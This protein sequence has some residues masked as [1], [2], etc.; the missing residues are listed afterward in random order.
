MLQEK[1]TIDFKTGNQLDYDCCKPNPF[2][3]DRTLGLKVI[4]IHLAVMENGYNFNLIP[5][6]W[7]KFS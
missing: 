3:F 2:L 1:I 6:L 4:E 5:R 7:R